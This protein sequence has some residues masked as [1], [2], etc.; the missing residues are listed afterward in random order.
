MNIQRILVIVVFLSGIFC[1]KTASADVDVRQQVI[2]LMT[3]LGLH[4][5]LYAPVKISSDK[6]GVISIT[7]EGNFPM[8]YMIME[9]CVSADANMVIDPNI[10]IPSSVDKAVIVTHGWIDKAGSDW[11]EDIA[12]E[13]RKKVDPN[14][15]VCIFFDWRGGA[16]VVN[17]IDAVKYARDIAGPR[18]AQAISKL[19]KFEHIH[20][21]GHSAGSWAIDSAAKIIAKEKKPEIH[22]TFLD[23]Y[24]PP[25]WSE[26]DLG[27]IENYKSKWSDHYYTK[28]ITLSSTQKNLTEAY[29]VD[30]TDI[31]PWIKEH[32]FPYRWYYATIA[33]EYRNSDFEAGD[34]VL[35]RCKGLDYGFDRSLEAGK[36]KWGKSLTLQKGNEAIKL[37]K[38]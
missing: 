17:P 24:V 32:E 11:P 2:K 16:A 14:E 4:N 27:N 5:K 37:T 6:S 20:L 7:D 12:E 10:K 34:K 1:L 21:I 18:L 8:Q 15:W 25:G 29:N 3:S 36:L 28:D 30:I 23:A 9:P 13:I 31:D 35:T 22:L 19:G 38:P 26:S 33:G